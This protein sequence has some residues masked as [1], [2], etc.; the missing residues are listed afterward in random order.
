MFHRTQL[1]L[2]KA[3]SFERSGQWQAAVDLCEKIFESSWRSASV[4][5]LLEALLRL[6]LL[7]STRSDREIAHDYYDPVFEI[8][9]VAGDLNRMGRAK[10]GLGI[11]FQRAGKIDEAETC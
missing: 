5:D 7:Y 1:L 4:D 11:L 6:G 10:N 9:D 8:S 3:N 2:D